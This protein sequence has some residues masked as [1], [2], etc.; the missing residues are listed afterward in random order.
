MY[1]LNL[2]NKSSND[3]SFYLVK[4]YMNLNYPIFDINNPVDYV[5]SQ[6]FYSPF[7]ME[8]EMSATVYILG[9]PV[10]TLT[11]VRIISRKIVTKMSILG[12]LGDV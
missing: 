3:S 4:S 12:P 2:Y 11:L 6:T 9:T 8:V 5:W 1:L 7:Q 10:Y